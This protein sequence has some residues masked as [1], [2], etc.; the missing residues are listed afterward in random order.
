MTDDFQQFIEAAPDALL[1]VGHDGVIAL[2]NTQAERLFGY[3]RHELVGQPVELL[4][5]ESLRAAH[6]H[7][8]SGFTRAPSRRSMGSGLELQG[9]RKDGSEFPVEI[10]LSP[11]TVRE[12]PRVMAAIRDISERQRMEAAARAAADLLRQAVEIQEDAFAVLDRDGR[13]ALHNSAYRALFPSGFAGPLIGRTPEELIDLSL[14]ALPPADDAVRERLRAE[15]LAVFEQPPGALRVQ[16]ESRT[17]QV[18]SRQT[19]DGALVVTIADRTEDERREEAL[20]RAS[21]AKSEFLSAMSH[22]LRTPL[23]AILGFASLLARDRKTPLTDRQKEMVEHVLKGGRHLLLL[24]DEVL[25]LSKVESGRVPLSLEPVS[26][27]PLLS[28]VATTLQPMA[29]RAGV[30]LR[31]APTPVGLPSAHAD[32]TRAAQVLMNLGSNAIKYGRRG[33]HATFSVAHA[34]GAF[35]RVIVRDDGVGIPE[36]KHDRIFQPFQRAGQ[37]AGPIEG[38]GIG[39]A[40][41][42]RL[43]ELMG[44]KVGFRSAADAGS[45]FWVDLP[46]HEQAAPGPTASDVPAVGALLEGARAARL[47]VVYVEDNPSNVAFMRELLSEFEGVELHVAPTA[48]IGLEVVR[49]RRPWVVLMDINLPGMSGLDA[50]RLLKG[51]P[52]TRDIPVIALSAAAMRHDTQRA[53]AAGF[54]RYLTKPV[55]VAELIGALEALLPAPA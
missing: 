22:E 30:E 55:D 35:V 52:E 38:T 10:S 46:V 21:A 11:I 24:I 5:P 51:W 12:G 32:R 49:A 45:E 34:D 50:L 7:H 36:E 37:E 16:W 28:E 8:R 44:G 25:D 17:W 40:L 54:Y 39:L 42:R 43:V 33:G 19:P 15:R 18:T 53:E 13:I 31:L 9:R 29:E 41:S 3:A 27:A 2:V 20:R 1:L 47:E 14:S 26:L 23:N 6:V 4:V 48:E